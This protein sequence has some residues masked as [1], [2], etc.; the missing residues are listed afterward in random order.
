MR[1]A[2]GASRQQVVGQVL[3]QGLSLTVGGLVIGLASAAGL[4]RLAASL[5]AGVSPTDLLTYATVATL[6]VIAA[7]LAILV[8]A[9]RAAAID[10][11]IALRAD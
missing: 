10:P 3:R 5:V 4:S 7:T 1:L 9:G 11:Q 8:P 6:V 2:L